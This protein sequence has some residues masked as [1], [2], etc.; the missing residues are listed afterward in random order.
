MKN[1]PVKYESNNIGEKIYALRGMRV[2][3]DFDLAEVYG[4]TT[5][6]LNEQTKRNEKRFPADFMFQLTQK[7][8]D[9]LRSHF[10]SSS[11]IMRSQFATASKRNIRHL[12]YV[13]TEHGA[14]MAANVLNSPAAVDKGAVPFSSVPFSSLLVSGRRV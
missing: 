10:A 9:D 13:F 6:R 14:L 1:G 12:P 2:I 11:S 8:W 5:K 3:L 7:E 4:V